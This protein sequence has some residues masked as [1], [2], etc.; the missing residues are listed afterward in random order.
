M[1]FDHFDF[2]APIYN[3]VGAYSALDTMLELGAFPVMGACLMLAAAQDA[4]QVLYAI[5]ST[6]L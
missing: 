4:S 3:R 2:I 1:P 6:K 5:K